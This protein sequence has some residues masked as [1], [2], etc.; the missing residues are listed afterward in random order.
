MT[1]R[2][3]ATRPSR[4]LLLWSIRALDIDPARFSFVD[5]GSG[6]GRMHLTAARLPLRRVIGVEFSRRRHDQ[7]ADNIAASNALRKLKR[8]AS[9]R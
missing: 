5:Y 1:L 3:E 4:L 6:R 2:G 9:K 7:A 8:R